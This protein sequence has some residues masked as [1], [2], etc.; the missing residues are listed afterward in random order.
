MKRRR[1]G[2][3]MK[4]W[5][6]PTR[7]EKFWSI[8]E[9]V[10]DAEVINIP[11][12]S[13][14]AMK[15]FEVSGQVLAADQ[16]QANVGPR[17]LQHAK[18]HRIDGAIWAWLDPMIQYEDF[19]AWKEGGV[20][21]GE[22]PVPNIHMLTYVWM[23]TQQTS[24]ASGDNPSGAAGNF[25]PNPTQDLS[26]LLLRDDIMK[27]GTIPVFGIVPRIFT[28]MFRLGGGGVNAAF[29]AIHTANAGM[30]LHNQVA[31]V[32]WPRIPKQ[33]LNLRKGENLTCFAAAWPGP[34][35]FT[36]AVDDD[37]SSRAVHTLNQSRLLCSV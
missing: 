24:D 10:V 22:Q 14:T 7:M 1:G 2:M 20:V 26:K 6:K 12:S 19:G 32:P 37:Q 29:D 28:A 34:G 11:A 16:A 23:K 4:P 3:A 30:Y 35:S 17:A 33:G 21:Y 8:L 27:W 13:T 36:G 9:T 31:K 25:N 15:I 18:L 5:N